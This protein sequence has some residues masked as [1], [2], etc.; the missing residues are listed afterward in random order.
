ML[1]WVLLAA[2]CTP[3]TQGV[4]YPA[5]YRAD[6]LH[7]VTVDRPDA[8]VRD[9]YINPEAVEY[10]RRGNRLPDDTI[11]VVEAY[12]AEVDANGDPLL[13]ELGRYI[14]AAPMAMV[15]VAQKRSHWAEADFPGAARAG[16]WNF[17]SFTFGAGTPFDE[18]LTACFN[19]HQ[20]APQTDF[21]YSG[22]Q[23][24]R[25][26]MTDTTQY[27]FCELRRRTPCQ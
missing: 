9:I 10:L 19:C 1:L 25:F 23:L 26:V 22:R 27:F 18:D 13:D 2:A 20:A 24:T 11:I 8:T 21:V 7:Y 12:H 14:K 5:N 17:G 15:H 6:F 3:S 4:I 16:A